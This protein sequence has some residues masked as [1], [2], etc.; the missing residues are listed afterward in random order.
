VSGLQI[1]ILTASIIVPFGAPGITRT[2]PSV[3]R[4]DYE[5]AFAFYASFVGHGLDRIV[6]ADN[7]GADLQSMEK[8]AA[9]KNV[10]SSVDF[11]T[12]DGNGFPPVFGRCFGESTILDQVM[13]SEC[14]SKLPA[15]AIYWKSTGRYQ[16]K[17][18]YQMMQT[19]PPSVEFYC[20]MRRRGKQRWADM[21]FMSWTRRGYHEIL[22]GIAPLLR[23]DTRNN[24]PGEEALFDILEERLSKSDLR[25]ARSFAAEPFI[26]GIRAFDNRNWSTGRQRLVYH[27][28]S[29]QRR[30]LHKVIF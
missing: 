14:C 15:E 19:M 23:E 21:R 11:L 13:S 6:F 3:R 30:F 16:I 9:S 17:N 20:D 1:L 18:F 26:D 5:Q 4:Q 24:R 25:F 8:I 12:F 29:L 28:R 2:D 10:V 22:A 27:A 7:T